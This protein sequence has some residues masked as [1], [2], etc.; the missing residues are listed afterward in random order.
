MRASMN[1]VG[2]I[3]TENEI[4]I[5]GSCPHTITKQVIASD[6]SM[7]DFLLSNAASVFISNLGFKG[8]VNVFN[9]NGWFGLSA[10]GFKVQTKLV[11]ARPNELNQFWNAI[12]DKEIT[13]NNLELQSAIKRVSSYATDEYS[14]IK[15][16]IENDKMDVIGD[17]K[18]MGHYA[19]E[20]VS[21]TNSNVENIVIGVNANY[22]LSALG[23]IDAEHVNMMI[24]ENNKP[25]YIQALGNE[26]D[27]QTW[28]VMPIKID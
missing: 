26:K 4:Q 20:E 17:T 3:S 19:E 28:L 1:G 23:C 15:I 18:E 21:I 25:V 6:N 24:S 10:E 9:H 12:P 8:M 7:E 14:L 27:V 11:D 22:I 5:T 2:I 13:V 16:S